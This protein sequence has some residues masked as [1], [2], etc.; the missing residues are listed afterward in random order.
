VEENI[1]ALIGTGIGA[2]AIGYAG[3][4]LLTLFEKWMSLI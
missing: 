1:A 4:K 3:S 2:F